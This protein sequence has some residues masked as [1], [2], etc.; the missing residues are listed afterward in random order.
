MEEI[1]SAYASARSTRGRPTMILAKT[2]KGK[3]V[4]FS[5]G[6]QGWHGKAYKKDEAEKAIAELEALLE[7][8]TAALPPIPKPPSFDSLAPAGR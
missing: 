8:E 4:S 3:G 6:K 5:E 2:L 1:L 7:P